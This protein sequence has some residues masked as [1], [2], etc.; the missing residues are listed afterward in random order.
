MFAV[1]VLAASAAV[2]TPTG[3]RAPRPAPTAIA[4]VDTTFAVKGVKVT[5]VAGAPL[6]VDAGAG[7]SPFGAGT[8]RARTLGPAFV[9]GM[10]TRHDL[11]LRA[12]RDVE[13]MRGGVSV[14]TLK[15]GA[16]VRVLGVD[17][18][19]ARVETL[20][21]AV[22]AATVA[23]DALSPAAIEFVLP[24][25]F[26]HETARE[27]VIYAGKDVAGEPRATLPPGTR[28]TVAE[29][30]GEVLRVRTHGPVELEGWVL[31]PAVRER[32]TDVKDISPVQR[33]IPTHEVLTESPLWASAK[34]GAPIG[35]LRGGALLKVERVGVLD[36]KG[37][38]RVR[39]L[40]DVKLEAWVTVS[41]LRNL[42]ES[43]WRE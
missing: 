28:L 25:E 7:K 20:A 5:V 24:G 43:V 34:G 27:A 39:T 11:G 14:G 12:Q 37:R 30:V 9:D 4:A 17:K 2:A 18:D 31:A 22:V 6:A 35:R 38:I 26:S 8:V 41:D 21:P 10:I 3:V 1:V 29:K 42:E 13:L 40:G 16:I 33:Q 19:G 36:P 32:L 15:R 23:S